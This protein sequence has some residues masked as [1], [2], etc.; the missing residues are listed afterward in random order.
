MH[1]LVDSTH[2]ATIHGF[3]VVRQNDVVQS[4]NISFTLKLEIITIIDPEILINFETFDGLSNIKP[5][6]LRKLIEMVE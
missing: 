3:W 1:V 5:I 2:T 6:P 4:R